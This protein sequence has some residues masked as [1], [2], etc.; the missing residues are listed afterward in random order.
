MKSASVNPVRFESGSGTTGVLLLHGYTGS[1]P[2]VA[3][4][5]EFLAARGMRVVAPLLPGHG[6]SAQDL[7]RQSWRDVA[8]AA[9]AEL[10]D[11]Q[12]ECEHVFVGGLSMGG[13][14]ALYLGE[15]CAGIA[16]ILSMSSPLYAKSKLRFLLPIARRLVDTIPKSNAPD[17]SVHDPSCARFLWSYDCE[18]LQF[19]SELI[20][21]IAKVRRDLAKVHAPLLVFAG[22]HDNTVPPKAAYEIV[23]R[24]SSPHKKL[25]LLANSG[26]CLSV[27]S[28]RQEV[29]ATTARWIQEITNET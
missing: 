9:A 6:T 13:L 5:G 3:L 14:L 26:H 25:V 22:A 2:E 24:A 21:L 29:F 1:P 12:G 7:N 23:K 16:G 8:D 19:A 27:D 17:L 18:A 10:Y 11:L 15:H 4:L 20:S 28:E